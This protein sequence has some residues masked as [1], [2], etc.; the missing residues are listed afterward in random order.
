MRS[1][2][3]FIPGLIYP[4]LNLDEQ[5]IPETPALKKI[6][7]RAVRGKLIKFGFTDALSML[8]NL[9]RNA[10]QDFPIAAITR[11]VDDQSGD[12]AVWMRAD[13]VHLAADQRSLVLFD[14]TYL[15]LDQHEALVFA[16]EARNILEAHNIA[17]EV[18]GIN[19]WYIRLDQDPEICTTPI[20]EVYGQDIARYLPSGNGSMLWNSMVNEIQ[21]ALHNCPLNE[22][23]LQRG[24][25]TMNSI[26]F[27]GLGSLPGKVSAPWNHVYTDEEVVRGFS[28]LSGASCHD[29]PDTI[30]T[31][32]EQS[33]AEDDV[34]LVISFGLRHQQY[35]DM[36]GWQDFVSYLEECWFERLLEALTDREIE[37]LTLLTEHQQFTLSGKSLLAVWRRKR[38]LSFFVN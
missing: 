29:L 5:D 16:A 15:G 24:E 34:L 28:I 6:L 33:A 10:D 21:M 30:D 9:P 4:S 3:L 20:H 13:P 27:W 2:T 38:P 7:S 37:E 8:F 25:K 26:W 19:R 31:V 18:P 35:S 23:R 12:N 14:E 11:Q 32:I 22:E 36:K 1:L 17:L